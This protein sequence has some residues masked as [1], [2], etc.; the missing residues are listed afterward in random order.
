MMKIVKT[1]RSDTEPLE[2]IVAGSG[3]EK[4]YLG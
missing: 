1:E 2:V 3:S 4:I